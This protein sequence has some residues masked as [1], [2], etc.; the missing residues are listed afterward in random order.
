MARRVSHHVAKH[1]ARIAKHH[2]RLNGV[3]VYAGEPRIAHKSVRA[4]RLGK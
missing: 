4:P 3:Q 2:A 1:K